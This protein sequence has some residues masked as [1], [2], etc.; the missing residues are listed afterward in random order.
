MKFAG[1]HFIDAREHIGIPVD[2]V[3]GIALACGDER[4]M[5]SYGSG[6]LVGAGEKTVLS[7]EDPAFDR[8]LGPVIVYADL[9]IFQKPGER[10]PVLQR[11]VDS[12]HELVRWREPRLGSQ[13]GLSQ[14]L[15]QRLGLS[16]PD[17]QTHRWGLVLD[18]ALDFVKLAVCVEHG[19]AKVGLAEFCF[20]VFAPGVGVAAGFYFTAVSEQRIESAG[21]IRLDDAFEVFEEF[22]V[23]AEGEV[24]AEVEDGASV[25]VVS[26]VCGDFA[27]TNV[28]FEFA[29]LNFNR[30]VVGLDDSGLEE[31]LLLKLV[32]KGERKSG[33]LHPITLSGAWNGHIASSESFLLAVVGQSI[34]DLADDDL[35][36]EAGSGV[37]TGNGLAGLFACDDVGLALRAGAGLLQVVDDF[38]AGAEHLEL[39]SE[40]VADKDCSDSAI[41]A[42]GILGLNG[43]MK[44]LVRN[45]G[46]IFE[47]VLDAGRFFRSRSRTRTIFL[48]I[49]SWARIVLLGLLAVIAL[50]ALLGLDD[51]DI[52]LFLEVREQFFELLVAVE[53]LLEL[54]LQA[55]NESGKALNLRLGLEVLLLQIC[56][57]VHV[58]PVVVSCVDYTLYGI[59]D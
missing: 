48:L 41:R 17:C 16:S 36:Q 14:S 33:G 29:V 35:A 10:N 28:V 4:Q 20:K 44:R 1:F 56:V 31:I 38:Q 49:E 58:A 23:S 7:H 54:L 18:L 21:G 45:I 24:F 9:W 3:D 52:E 13:Y 15:Y 19:V 40:G 50:V 8:P 43:V 11:V 12:L 25:I 51:Y 42:D 55:F 59:V 57:V 30:G 5:N 6:A 32:Q 53:G 26:D 46:T 22:E 27:L 47:N 2:R 34:F 37:A 39:V